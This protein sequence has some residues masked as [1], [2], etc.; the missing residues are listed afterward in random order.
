VVPLL[1]RDR[2]LADLFA[3]A[4]RAAAGSG[5]VAVVV[6]EAGIG[7]TALLHELAAAVS[8]RMRVLWGGCEAL[9]TPRP[10]GPLH[11]IAPALGIDP[12]LPRER[13]FPTVL[14][15]AGSIPTLLVVEDAHWADHATLDLLKFIAR[16][17]A[18]APLFLTLS[19]RDD[20]IGPDHPLIMVLGEA[21]AAVR[22]VA[23]PPLSREAVETLAEGR[24]GVFE[25]TGGNPFYVTEVLAGDAH[26]VPPV[27]RD[28]VLARAAKLSPDA[29]Q[30]VEM[31]SVVP[32]RAELDLL[33]AT[34]EAT[35]EATRCGIVRLENHAI[36][37][38]HELARRAME[39]SL[40]DLRRAAMHRA[41]LARLIARSEPSLAR[42]AHH[43]AG[44]GD[45]A[46]IFDFAPLAAVE[47]AKAGAHFE[48]ASHL[49]AALRCATAADAGRAML[50]ES[51]GYECCLLDES[52]EALACH[53]E[54]TAIRHR[55]GHKLREGDNLRWQ[56]R[57]HWRLGRTVEARKKS[58]EAIAILQHEPSRELAM[59]YNQQSHLH[60]LAQ[61]KEAA[62]EWGTRALELAQ[63]LGDEEIVAHAMNS[64]GSACAMANDVTG[65]DAIEEALRL[66]LRHG[67]QEHAAR[68]YGNL[69][70][71]AVWLRQYA[72]A[73]DVIAKGLEY[74]QERD[75]VFWQ[76]YI[77]VFRA[78]L[79]LEQGRWDDALTDAEVVLARGSVSK[80]NRAFALVVAA[81]VRS[82]RGDAD[83][84]AWFDEA[85]QLE[86]RIPELQGIGFVAVAHA[87]AAWLRGDSASAIEELR[88]AMAMDRTMLQRHNLQRWLWRVGGSETAPPPAV[89]SGDPYDEALLLSDAGD[90][91]SLQRAIEILERLGDGCLIHTLRQKLRARGVRGPRPSTRAHPSGLTAREVEILELLDE[92]LRNADIARRL[93]LSPKTVD[94]HVSSVLA[95]LNVR[96]RGEA[97][98]LFRSQKK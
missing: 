87:E 85:R 55:L 91:E 25:L 70:A 43:A 39:A 50:L 13:L 14:A 96:S 79:R 7:K 98:R 12:D 84:Q 36:V 9:F 15:A 52:Q 92:G 56:S 64:I 48:A 41:I 19:Y 75:I 1:E 40:S 29:R 45:A 54:A 26:A 34:D 86:R 53:V 94:H 37:F 32:G 65:L 21:G 88:D 93:H 10:L 18:R 5:A 24:A 58:Q 28:A 31:A 68:S 8:D 47:A 44:T 11:D 38:R 97:A 4:E 22:R 42:V 51:L 66:S 16:R 30:V 57:L 69:S 78:R 6:G 59:A 67:F 17:V 73:E 49:R 77:T 83:T 82:R 62:I 20:E 80:I 46:A 33:A 90:A 71:L 76:T 63:R 3:T 95:K 89:A 35:E 23:L 61:E 60:M 74:C 72:S 27:V 81:T 2:P